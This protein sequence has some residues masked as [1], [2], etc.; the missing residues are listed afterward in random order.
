MTAHETV[1]L[2]AVL[3]DTCAVIWL[4]E[5]L[6][7][8]EQAHAVIAHAGGAGGIVVSAVSAWEIGLLA[9]PKKS[10]ALRFLPDPQSWFRRFAASP[11]VRELPL[12]GDVAIEASSLPGDLHGDPA[13]RMLIATARHHGLPIVTRDR[14]ILA[15]AEA[16]FIAAVP[17]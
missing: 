7:L 17:C 12:T 5:G 10:G 9:R 11:G 1:R 8:S 15:Y 3:L 13:D 14:N 2:D 16:G 6:E 4:A